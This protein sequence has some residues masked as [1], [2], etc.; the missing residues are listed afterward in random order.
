MDSIS[1]RPTCCQAQTCSNGIRRTS[2]FKKIAAVKRWL[3]QVESDVSVGLVPEAHD[4]VSDHLITCREEVT[5]RRVHTRH[6]SAVIGCFLED[7][8]SSIPIHCVTSK[9]VEAWIEHRRTIPSRRTGRLV[10]ERPI[11]E[12]LQTLSAFFSWAA[13]RKLPPHLAPPLSPLALSA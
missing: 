7:P 8:V 4:H 1:K 10:G 9:D 13:K 12:P 5:M 11:A 3:A 6:E 2:S